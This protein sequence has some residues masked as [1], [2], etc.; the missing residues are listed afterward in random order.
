MNTYKVTIKEVMSDHP[1]QTSITTDKDLDYVREFFGLKNY[2]VEWYTIEN[3][4]VR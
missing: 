2:D 4:N 1:I 3:D